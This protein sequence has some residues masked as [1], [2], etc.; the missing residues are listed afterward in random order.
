MT[1]AIGVATLTVAIVGYLFAADFLRATAL[2]QDALQD[3]VNQLLAAS[4]KPEPG[5]ASREREMAREIAALRGELREAMRAITVIKRQVENSPV[6][7]ESDGEPVTDEDDLEEPRPEDAVA[8]QSESPIVTHHQTETIDRDWGGAAETSLHSA[9]D[10]RAGDGVSLIA[11]DC[12][13]TVCRLEVA[14]E[15]GE[16][17]PG[18]PVFLPM[19]IPWSGQSYLQSDPSGDP[20]RATLFVAREGYSLTGEPPQ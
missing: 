4:A 11:A 16:T 7:F 18:E 13:T 12:R 10:E 14:I 20:H 19:L 15:S 17:A 5:E 6:A 3:Q 8:G 1:Y 9:F 2:R